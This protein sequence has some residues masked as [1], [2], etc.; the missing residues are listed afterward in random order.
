MNKH[1]NI[2]IDVSEKLKN[3]K[4]VKDLTENSKLMS[5]DIY[6]TE[7]L[8]NDKDSDYVL[9]HFLLVF[10]KGYKISIINFE[11]SDIAFQELVDDIIDDIYACDY[12]YY[13]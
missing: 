1:N 3:S 5:T 10:A 2:Y 6:I 7:K 11:L 12:R 9:G 4:L 8:L 13:L